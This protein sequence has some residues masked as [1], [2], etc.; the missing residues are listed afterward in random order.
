MAIAELKTAFGLLSRMPVLW[1][2]GVV[3]GLCAAALWLVFNFSGT[4]F[5][6]RLVIVSGLIMLLF[7]TGMFWSAKNESGNIRTLV[8]GGIRYYFRVL[9]PILV[10]IFTV[11]LVFILIFITLTLAGVTP[12]PVLM[13][14]VSLV[15]MIPSI[16]LSFFCDTAAVFEDRGVFD[17]IRRS[18]E[19]V[20]TRLQEVIAFL[21]ICAVITAGVLFSLMILW[22]AVLYDRLEPLTHYT[23]AQIQAFTPDQ[24]VAIIGPDGTWITALVLFIA[25]LI[26]VPVLFTFKA[27]FFKS[28]AQKEVP[29]Q[30]ATG[31]FDSKGRWYKY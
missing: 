9:L 4:F 2:P 18:I 15:I 6:G 30:Q 24:L 11:M 5:A 13:A 26:L 8:E 20:G 16:I 3:C 12:D 14:A 19:L 10:I 17:A 25:C 7:I 23:E 28:L 1:I 31:E 29:V 21:A 22:E 27:C